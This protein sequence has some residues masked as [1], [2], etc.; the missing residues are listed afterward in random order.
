MFQEVFELGILVLIRFRYAVKALIREDT[1]EQPI[2]A[3]IATMIL[4]V[5]M[6]LSNIS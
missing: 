4:L 1:Y 5:Y 2:D 6:F 3:W